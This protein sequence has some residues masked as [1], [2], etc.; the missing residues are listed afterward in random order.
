VL[1]P[2]DTHSRPVTSIT[3]VLLPFV[4]YVYLLTLPHIILLVDA[5]F[6]EAACKVRNNLGCKGI[7]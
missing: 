3:A 5:N 4:T 7:L 1:L 6:L 2:S